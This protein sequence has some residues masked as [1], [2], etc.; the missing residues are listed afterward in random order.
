MIAT[1]RRSPAF[2]FLMRALAVLAGVCIALLLL[3]SAAG[4]AANQI[5]V[6]HPTDPPPINGDLSAPAW[7][8]AAKVNLGQ[9]LLNRSPADQPTTVY[10]LADDTYLYFGFEA[11]QRTPIQAAQ[12]TNDV[13]QGTDDQVTVYLWPE[14]DRGF[15]YGFTSNP[16]GTHYQFSTENTS[17]APT[18]ASAGRVRPD[19]YTVTMRIPLRVLRGGGTTK[20]W[21]V[22]FERKVRATLDD[23]VWAYDPGEQSPNSILY[24][25]YL[26]GIKHSVAAR[27]QPR[28]GLY[29]LDSVRSRASG[30]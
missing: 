18:W 14:G 24:A 22:Q 11:K 15:Q 1:N 6:P 3:V 16:I 9:N 30:G 20:A 2:A 25:G 21:R 8:H 23:F 12:H 5:D 4:A 27:P 26:N 17:Y 10:I 19:G 29:A 13:G 28:F 7:Q